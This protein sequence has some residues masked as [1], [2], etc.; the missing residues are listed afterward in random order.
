M[1]STRPTSGS[2]KERVCPRD[3]RGDLQSKPAFARRSRRDDGTNSPRHQSVDHEIK[4]AR[5]G[6]D[7]VRD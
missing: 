4:L 7:A 3:C 1:Y 6:L 5:R 2:S